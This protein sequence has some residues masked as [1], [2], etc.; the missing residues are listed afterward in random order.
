[1]G[2]SLDWWQVLGHVGRWPW[3]LIYVRSVSAVTSARDVNPTWDPC[4]MPW[5]GARRCT[6]PWGD[7]RHD[8]LPVGG[9]MDLFW[10]CGACSVWLAP[11]TCSPCLQT[12][13]PGEVRDF[14]LSCLPSL[15]LKPELSGSPAGTVVTSLE[16]E[17]V[18]ISTVEQLPWRTARG[19]ST[20]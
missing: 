19:S 12:L 7:W 2:Q 9:E 4:P 8:V 14:R 13:T 10:V 11:V 18:D 15:V 16:Q 17:P 6:G 20:K 3:D 1:M 5:V